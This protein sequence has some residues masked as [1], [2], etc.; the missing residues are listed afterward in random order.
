MRADDTSPRSKRDAEHGVEQQQQ[1][2]AQPERQVHRPRE[3]GQQDRAGH[4]RTRDL[5]RAA[6]VHQRARQQLPRVE[7]RQQHAEAAP[8][9]DRGVGRMAEVVADDPEIAGRVRELVD[10]PA[11]STAARR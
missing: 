6:V 8:G 2:V 3:R 7:L 9:A 1:A 5:E 10:R 4:T 11:G